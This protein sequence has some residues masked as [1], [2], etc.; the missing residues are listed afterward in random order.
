MDEHILDG[1][2]LG[3]EREK[4]NDVNALLIDVWKRL[5]ESRRQKFSQL[6]ISK[7]ILQI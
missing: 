4:P 6:P 7:W 5:R 2:D 3:I 1:A